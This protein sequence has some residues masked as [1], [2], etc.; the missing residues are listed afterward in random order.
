ML[1]TFTHSRLLKH[2]AGP[3]VTPGTFPIEGDLAESWTQP[4]E[5]TYVFKL[6][7]GVRW[8]TKPPGERPRADRRGRQVHLR[9]LP[10]RSRATPTRTCSPSVDKVEALDKYTVKFTLKEPY[11]WFLDMLANPDDARDHRQGVRGEVRRPQEG[12]GGGRH[13]AVDARQ[14]PAR[15]SASRS[16]ATRA[17]SCPGLPYIDRVEVTVDEDNASRMAAFLAG[18]YDLGWEYHGHDQPRRTG[19]RSRTRSSRS[20]RR[21]RRSSSRQPA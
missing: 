10:H 21:C 9:A 20:G 13:R 4:N 6:R 2:K 1:Y 5:T 8:H 11:A 3:A 7:K 12:R 16:C 14:L 18:K 17:T 19:C 15:T